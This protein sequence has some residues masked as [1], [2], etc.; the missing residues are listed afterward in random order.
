M[1]VP[2]TLVAAA[3]EATSEHRDLPLDNWVYPVIAGSIFFVL[4][5]ITW[6]FRNVAN[7]H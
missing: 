3:T 1:N 2:V 6:A 4:F 5:L 7:K